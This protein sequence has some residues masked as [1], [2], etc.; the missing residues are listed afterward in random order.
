MHRNRN[1][2][3]A[4]DFQIGSDRVGQKR[5]FADAAN[6]P[7]TTATHYDVLQVARLRT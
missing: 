4:R 7:L 2:R 5:S 1:T 6:P 3:N